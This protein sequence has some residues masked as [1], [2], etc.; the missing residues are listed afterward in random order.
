MLRKGRDEKH[1]V[2]GGVTGQLRSRC[3]RPMTLW[4]LVWVMDAWVSSMLY[5]CQ[6]CHEPRQMTLKLALG[7]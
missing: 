7:N 3:E 2:Q 4:L 6:E 1:R 5:Q